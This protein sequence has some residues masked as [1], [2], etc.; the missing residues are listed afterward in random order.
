MLEAIVYRH[1]RTNKHLGMGFVLFERVEAADAFIAK[2]NN[3][4]IM[5]QEV[6]CFHDSFGE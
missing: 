1:P 6:T 4:S 2:Y 3:G 5:G